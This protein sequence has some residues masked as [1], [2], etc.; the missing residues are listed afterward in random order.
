M[1]R[2]CSNK[3]SLVTDALWGIYFVGGSYI[4]GRNNS[5]L[6]RPPKPFH[7]NGACICRAASPRPW[8]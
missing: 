7:P 4:A 1:F 5:Q 2:M 6:A 8:N 3:M